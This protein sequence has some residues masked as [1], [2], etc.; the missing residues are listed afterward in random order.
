LQQCYSILLHQPG[1][2]HALT[3]TE[4]PFDLFGGGACILVRLSPADQRKISRQEVVRSV[5]RQ[6]DREIPEAAVRLRDLCG[7]G[8][9]P[10][11]SYPIDLAVHGPEAGP[12]RDFAK[13]LAERLG[14]G[15]RLTDVW[16]SPMSFPRP[17]LSIDVDRTRAADLGVSTADVFSTLQIYLGSYYVNDFNRFGRTWQVTV[18]A[19]P[20]G[21]G[22]VKDL[23]KD[24]QGVKVRNKKGDMVPLGAVMQIRD[25][26]GPAALEFFNSRPMVEITAN[27]G[28]GTSAEQAAA[29]CAAA[30]EEVRKELR[31][32]AEYQLTWLQ[33]M[34][35]AK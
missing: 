21:A 6:L 1:V 3:L 24:L 29:L 4:N 5:R 33:E 8:R 31:L 12:V 2:Q 17:Q 18:Q 28:P 7:P 34:A 13:K 35:R 15:N 16:A 26:D 25:V 23:V 27:P 30:A 19:A 9:F 10:R 22:A 11:C 20:G 14:R 32:S